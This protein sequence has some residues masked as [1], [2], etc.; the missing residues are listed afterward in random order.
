MVTFLHLTF[1][2]WNIIYFTIIIFYLCVELVLYRRICGARF[3]VST[4]VIEISYVYKTKI[5]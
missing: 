5:N 2:V 1:F 4:E 3:S